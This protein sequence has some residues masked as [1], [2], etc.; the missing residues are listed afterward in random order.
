M[1]ATVLMSDLI[2]RDLQ[3]DALNAT[4]LEASQTKEKA[5]TVNLDLGCSCL[6]DGEK[7]CTCKCGTMRY[8]KHLCSTVLTAA[9]IITLLLAA[10]YGLKKLGSSFPID[11]DG[12]LY[13]AIMNGTIT[14]M[15]GIVKSVSEYAKNK[16][17][18]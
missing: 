4:A 16:T 13:Q 7:N 10:A 15:R 6:R 5:R 8:E 1:A 3:L 14:A 11:P 12:E 9:V 2:A 17:E 18:T